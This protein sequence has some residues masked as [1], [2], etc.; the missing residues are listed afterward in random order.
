M[1]LAMSSTQWKNCTLY[2][3]KP[4]VENWDTCN[5]ET[6]IRNASKSPLVAKA[7]SQRWEG[8]EQVT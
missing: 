4:K 5:T 3:A 1:M 8:G 2:T 7:S 6:Q